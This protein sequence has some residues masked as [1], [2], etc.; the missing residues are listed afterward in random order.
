MSLD[1]IENE[2]HKQSFVRPMKP[3]S[4]INPS[5]EDFNVNQHL[6]AMFLL[7]SITALC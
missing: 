2:E 3:D 1:K 7:F 6:I 4:I 5:I